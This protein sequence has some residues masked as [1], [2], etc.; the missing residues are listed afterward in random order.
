VDQGYVYWLDFGEWL[1]AP[2]DGGGP[3]ALPL[4][5]CGGDVAADAQYAY[6][7]LVDC[8]SVARIPHGG[9]TAEIVHPAEPVTM[10]P[11]LTYLTLDGSNIYCAGV[12]HVFVSHNWGPLEL[13][14]SEADRSSNGEITRLGATE[15]TRPPRPVAD[16]ERRR[17]LFAAGGFV[18][19]WFTDTGEQRSIVEQPAWSSH[20]V[21]RDKC[22]FYW[23]R[24]TLNYASIER[25]PIG[26]E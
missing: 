16:S 15:V 12:H 22:F 18:Y 10:S 24:Y 17:V 14:T 1:R 23:G 7:A 19:A 2:K 5:A 25:M 13:I 3:E 21:T 20:Q 4:E 8:A 6:A 9:T 11:G 26:Q